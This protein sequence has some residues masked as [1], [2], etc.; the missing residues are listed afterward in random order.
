MLIIGSILLA[1]FSP[2][3]YEVGTTLIPVL[4]T[5]KP[6]SKESESFI[7]NH[8]TPMDGGGICTGQSVHSSPL[9]A[10]AHMASWLW[11]ASSN[12]RY[13]PLASL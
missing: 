8:S 7:K 12:F 11:Y 4:Q 5:R 1:L 13:L 9:L 6:K 3:P 10:V 2:K